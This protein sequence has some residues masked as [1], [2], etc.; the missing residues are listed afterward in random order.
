MIG[1]QI[2]PYAVLSELGEGGMGRVYRA[3][4]TRLG[5]DVAIKV[6]H[7]A[8]SDR[9]EREA[10]DRSVGPLQLP[11]GTNSVAGFSMHPDGTHFLFDLSSGLAVRHLADRRLRSTTTATRLAAGELTRAPL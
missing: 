4:D 5:R 6:S 2:G 11:D 1:Q 8:F 3:R 7:E 10:R 9:F